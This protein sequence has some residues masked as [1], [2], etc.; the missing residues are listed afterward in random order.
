MIRWPAVAVAKFVAT[1]SAIV[2]APHLARSRGDVGT[3]R[4]PI[5]R[6][7]RAAIPAQGMAGVTDGINLLSGQHM[8]NHQD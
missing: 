1:H 5:S 6:R 4:E 8:L 2:D 7:R 3:A